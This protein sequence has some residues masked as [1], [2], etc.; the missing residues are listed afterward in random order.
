M[1][2]SIQGL[3]ISQK[4]LLQLTM[5]A[6]G[7]K[8]EAAFAKDG[9]LPDPESTDNHEFKIVLRIIRDGLSKD[10]TRWTRMAKNCVGVSEETTTGVKRL[11]EMQV[12]GGSREGV[13]QEEA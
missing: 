11:Y 1:R 6:E 12:S 4:S 5:T 7:V 10:P 9:T 13:W 2:H 3:I 8:A